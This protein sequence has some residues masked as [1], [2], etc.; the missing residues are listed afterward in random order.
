M[1]HLEQKCHNLD[2]KVKQ[3][4]VERNI[5]LNEN[6]LLVEAISG[7]SDISNQNDHL[8]QAHLREDILAVSEEVRRLDSVVCQI[9]ESV[10]SVAGKLKEMDVLRRTI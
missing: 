8:C 7:K 3:L 4:E 1:D 5:I 10:S 2:Q 6:E 9:Q